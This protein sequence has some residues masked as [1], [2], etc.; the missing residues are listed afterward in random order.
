MFFILWVRNYCRLKD[1]KIIHHSNRKANKFRTSS[2]LKNIIDKFIQQDSYWNPSSC[3]Y[4]PADFSHFT[5]SEK[6]VLRSKRTIIGF[7]PSQI[8]RVRILWPILTLP[9][10]VRLRR[11]SGSL[12]SDILQKSVDMLKSNLIH[13]IDFEVLILEELNPYRGDPKQNRWVVR[14]KIHRPS[15]S[16]IAK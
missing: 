4:S 13:Y 5:V 10:H 16:A 14:S 2:V 9:S 15:P 3:S 7:Y 1:N 6:R 11:R 8:N 12:P